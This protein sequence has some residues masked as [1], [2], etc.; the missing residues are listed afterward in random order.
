MGWTRNIMKLKGI[1]DEDFVNYKKCSMFLAFP[2]C[3]FKCEKECGERVCQ[4][5]PLALAQTLEVTTEKIVARYIQNPLSE[6]IVCG[7]LEPLDSFDDV[8]GL[9][10]AVRAHCDDDIVIYT[11]YNKSEIT[12]KIQRLQAYKNIIIKYGRFIPYR[13]THYD[14]VLGMKLASEN[15]YAERIS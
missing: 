14:E 15:Q 1:I 9:V 2:F 10:E 13:A 5:S 3:S 8:V 12:D 11:G 4:N 6:A 7:G